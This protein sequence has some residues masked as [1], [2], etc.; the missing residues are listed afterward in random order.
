MRGGD[1]D[2]TVR[3]VEV[4]ED[5]DGEKA[6]DVETWVITV[7]NRELAGLELREEDVDVVVPVDVGG[8]TVT[9]AEIEEAV[10]RVVKVKSGERLVGSAAAEM[11][12]VS[13]IGGRKY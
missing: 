4:G 5:E 1:A 7:W 10:P 3:A 13:V 9:A 12:M 11:E 6:E 2:G 8:E